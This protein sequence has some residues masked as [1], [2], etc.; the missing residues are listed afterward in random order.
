MEPQKCTIYDHN[1]IMHCVVY[2]VYLWW[3]DR[4]YARKVWHEAWTRCVRRR[5][6]GDLGAHSLLDNDSDAEDKNRSGGA[7]II[8]SSRSPRRSGFHGWFSNFD[9]RFMKKHFGGAKPRR[10]SHA[11]DVGMDMSDNLFAKSPSDRMFRIPPIERK[12]R[13]PG[14]PYSPPQSPKTTM[15]LP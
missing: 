13:L 6:S 9:K 7:I 15:T 1:H 14:E 8:P 11:S 5:S 10:L 2:D 4:A 3:P 12:K